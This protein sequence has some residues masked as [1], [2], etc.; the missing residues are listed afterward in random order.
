MS[1]RDGQAST[2]WRFHVSE[3]D[4]MKAFIAFP[5]DLPLCIEAFGPEADLLS[6]GCLTGHGLP[7]P[8]PAARH[9]PNPLGCPV[10]G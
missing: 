8:P 1:S 7:V 9:T 5:R 3:K 10:W 2:G 6:Q 4:D